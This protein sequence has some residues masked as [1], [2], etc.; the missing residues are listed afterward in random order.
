MSNDNDPKQVYLDHESNT[1]VAA[2]MLDIYNVFAAAGIDVYLALAFYGK[3]EDGVA[4]GF[5][6]TPG[7]NHQ[8]IHHIVSANIGRAPDMR[9]SSAGDLIPGGEAN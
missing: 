2:A 3:S 4:V 5:Y 6:S 9:V 7:C 1:K 8:T